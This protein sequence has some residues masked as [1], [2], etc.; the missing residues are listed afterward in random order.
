MVHVAEIRVLTMGSLVCHGSA[1]VIL[2]I[3]IPLRSSVG[4]AAHAASIAARMDDELVP[5]AQHSSYADPYE[6]LKT[7]MKS[8]RSQTWNFVEGCV[9]RKVQF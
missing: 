1:F 2:P 8:S 3:R 9:Y 5:A 4:S 7:M 6:D